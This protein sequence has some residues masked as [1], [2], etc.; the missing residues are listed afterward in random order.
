MNAGKKL[1]GVIVS[2]LAAMI[3][4]VGTA[5]LGIYLLMMVVWFHVPVTD[6]LT[7]VVPFIL[8]IL[9]I[10]W[11]LNRAGIALRRHPVR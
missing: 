9:I 11:L 6:V 4:I 8:I 10:A 2:F 5:G 1:L 7:L 3:V